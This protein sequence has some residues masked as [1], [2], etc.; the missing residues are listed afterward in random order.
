MTGGSGVR[1]KLDKLFADLT[2]EIESND[3]LR[4]GPLAT[5]QERATPATASLAA[6]QQQK[7]KTVSDGGWRPAGRRARGD[8]P[9]C[10]SER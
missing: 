9:M 5:R 1:P 6:A 10:L 8:K 4:Y 2:V 3:G 7:P